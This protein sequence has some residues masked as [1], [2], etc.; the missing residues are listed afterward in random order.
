MERRTWRL[1][2]NY[3]ALFLLKA[4]ESGIAR[5]FASRCTVPLQSQLSLNFLRNN[6]YGHF[7][8]VCKNMRV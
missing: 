7:E 3:L 1:I 8:K 2:Q 4:I 5:M 6:T